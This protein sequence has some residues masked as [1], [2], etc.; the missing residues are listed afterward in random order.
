[1]RKLVAKEK[2]IVNSLQESLVN[3]GW[4]ILDSADSGIYRKGSCILFIFQE[5]HELP[6]E[7]RYSAGFPVNYI[8]NFYLP[9]YDWWVE[10]DGIL[11][12]CDKFKR[13]FGN[14]AE[15]LKNYVGYLEM[16][17]TLDASIVL[18]KRAL[19]TTETIS[20]VKRKLIK[21]TGPAI[22]N[23]YL[24]TGD[25]YYLIRL[26][27]QQADDK[28]YA[29]IP[30]AL[31][32]DGDDITYEIRSDIKPLTTKEEQLNALL[33]AKDFEVFT[34]SEI[35]NDSLVPKWKS[36]ERLE[37]SC[38]ENDDIFTDLDLSSVQRVSAATAL[39]L[40]ENP[41]ILL[42][43]GLDNVTCNK[44]L[45]FIK[46]GLNMEYLK[47]N[48]SSDVFD[49]LYGISSNY[50]SLKKYAIKGYTAERIRTLYND[51]ITSFSRQE[52]ALA[53]EGYNADQIA[54]LR[55]VASKGSGIAHLRTNKPLQAMWLSDEITRGH[56][57]KLFTWMMPYATENTNQ[58]VSIPWS[59]IPESLQ[60]YVKQV[61]SNVPD[62]EINGVP[63]R[64]VLDKILHDVSVLYYHVNDGITLYSN[65]NYLTMR[66]NA[67]LVSNFMLYNCVIAMQINSKMYVSTS[68]LESLGLDL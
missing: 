65:E 33:N 67:I 48:Y 43:D 24:K 17:A 18:S 39:G 38:C 40:R 14:S 23:L 41:S 32:M 25:S 31:T 8:R 53:E 68:D 36:E 9:D 10:Y 49:E 29:L 21:Y 47:G 35:V 64:T 30:L 46:A 60:D 63:W 66:K 1:M 55:Y 15:Q 28:I 52:E 58:R 59:I 61:F 19:Y 45:G 27:P 11:V 22:E 5:E 62:F 6:T 42:Q 13:N 16:L 56:H 3:K 20:Q 54:F 50:V 4:Q 26:L 2:K 44:L 57:V 7:K 51:F 34:M 37:V 12:A